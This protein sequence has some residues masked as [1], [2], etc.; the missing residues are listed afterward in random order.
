MLHVNITGAEI[1]PFG[2]DTGIQCSYSY[3]NALLCSRKEARNCKRRKKARKILYRAS[4]PI[5]MYK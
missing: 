1:L 4:K 3:C 2:P 5:F